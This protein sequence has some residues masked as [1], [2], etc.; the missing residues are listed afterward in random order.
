MTMAVIIV[1]IVLL[2]VYIAKRCTSD[3]S[4]GGASQA[5][6]SDAFLREH[7]ES[8]RQM[9][10]EYEQATGDFSLREDIQ[11]V[12]RGSEPADALK[13]V[14]ADCAPAGS[15]CIVQTHSGDTASVF[16]PI[17]EAVI[18]PPD[19]IMS[20]AHSSD[21]NDMWADYLHLAVCS[22]FAALPPLKTLFVGVY[23]PAIE[24]PEG[25]PYCYLSLKA[26]R[27]AVE[28]M[29]G[30]LSGTRYLAFLS[31]RCHDLQDVTPYE[32]DYYPHVERQAVHRAFTPESFEHFVGKLLSNWGYRYEVT[33]RTRDGGIDILAYNDEPVVGGTI[34][35]QC[36]CYAPGN[37]V[38]VSAVRELY[39]VVQDRRANKG[40]L[41][42]TS[43]FSA[44]ARRFATG[45]QIELING[46]ELQRLTASMV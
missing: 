30:G 13:T 26:N 40:I 34:F 17:D 32:V 35:V 18:S 37:P 4:T 28:N 20:S 3:T 45:K 7:L 5:A 44:D 33:S 10:M 39:A 16:I 9:S 29:P 1:V 21:V 2:L 41:V 15:S 6:D 19:T 24:M 46:E 11:R 25:R 14:L 43:D 8:L 38:G 12:L 42:T 36:K 31:V 22:T 27:S 23:N